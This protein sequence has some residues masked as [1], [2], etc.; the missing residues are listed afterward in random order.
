MTA[1]TAPPV[2]ASAPEV[3]A[4]GRAATRAGWT[5]VL[6]GLAVFGLMGLAGIAMRLTQAGEV[7]ISPR[8]FY[9]LMTVHGAGMLVGGLLAMMGA[10]VFVL[11][12]TLALSGRRLAWAYGTIVAGTLA[13]LVAVV[14][15]GFATGWTFLAPLPFHSAGEWSPWATATFLAGMLL[16]GVGFFLFCLDL[17]QSAVD[18]YGRLSRALGLAFLR[19]RDDE[20]P[21]PQV[22]GATVVALEGLLASAVGTTMIVALIG[23][24]ID[25]GV[26]ID[27]LWAKNLTYFFGHTLANL[28]IYIAAGA[29]YVLVPLYAGRPWKT[30][31]PIV[32]AWMAT[33]V[34]V[35]TAYSHH[36]YMDFV[37]PRWAS[38]VSTTA[39]FSAA[40]PVAVVTIYTGMMLVWGSRYRWTLASTLLYLGFAGWAIGGVGAVIDSLIPANYRL[41]NTLWVP[42][43]FHTYLLLG[44]M[45]WAMSFL[46]HLAE[47]MAGRTAP[48]WVTV[49]APGLMVVGGYLLVGSWYAAGALGVP[50]RYAVQPLGSHDTALAG[51]IGAIVFAAGFLLLLVA[52]GALVRTGLA[53][54]RAAAPA[55]A[56]AAATVGDEPAPPRRE[57]PPL[58]PQ[59][60]IAAGAMFATIAAAAFLP[61]IVEASEDTAQLHHLDHAVQF[62][63]GAALGFTIAATLAIRAGSVRRGG[64]F[65]LAFV[66][67]APVAML[68]VMLPAIYGDIEPHKVL[69]ALYHVGIGLLGLVTGL[70]AARFGRAAGPVVLVTAVG[71]GFLYAGGVGS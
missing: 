37:Q 26:T 70:A 18:R 21:P 59:F 11:R 3:A 62:L 13:V 39:S 23:R 61:S 30:T 52:V 32:V 44:V 35:A 38:Y 22:I 60:G 12:P 64:T 34:L 6:T 47:G 56:P 33:L 7:G 36:L 51:S 4:P 57:A 24:T 29:I 40:I 41:H 67:A 71:M 68:L 45:L 31:K 1:V 50:R 63:F 49:A 42:A 8:W 54:R 27:A 46:V 9:R 5:L 19:D 48:R 65:A 17:L 20:P 14:V 2:H 25:S 58:S 55:G 10:L 53:R 28:I 15:G 69:H 16:V 43:H 66:V